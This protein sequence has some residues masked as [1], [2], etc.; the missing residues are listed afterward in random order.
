MRMF[1]VSDIG[2]QIFSNKKHWQCVSDAM[3]SFEDNFPNC[4]SV[5]LLGGFKSMCIHNGQRC[6][7]LQN[8]LDLKMNEYFVVHLAQQNCTLIFQW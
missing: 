6:F 1:L 2:R 4:S 3:Y 5:A 8:N 7:Y